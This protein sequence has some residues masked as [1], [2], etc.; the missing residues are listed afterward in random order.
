L[1]KATNF[2]GRLWI[3]AWFNLEIP[4]NEGP[5]KFRGLSGLIFEIGD[6]QT[7]FMPFLF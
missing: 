2:G 5:Y 4:I 1:Q 3:I 6:S 7:Q